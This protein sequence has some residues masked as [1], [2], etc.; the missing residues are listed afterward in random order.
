MVKKVSNVMPDFEY[1][2]KGDN[3]TL[4][5]H[6]GT[7]GDEYGVIDIVR[8]CVE[9]YEGR[10][11]D[12]VFVPVVSPSAVKAKIR[13]NSNGFDLNR[14][15][16]SDSKEIEVI[17]NIKALDG[18]KFNLM[19]SFHEDPV[20]EEYYVYESSF[21]SGESEKIKNLNQKLKGLGI[22]LL[23]GVDDPDDPSLGFEFVEGYRKF[24]VDKNNKSDGYITHWALI[25]AGVKTAFS[26]ETPS[27]LSL[28]KKELIVDTFFKDLLIKGS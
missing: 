17:E 22:K 4:L 15:F 18:Y 20:Y 11:P 5:I 6:S 27:K 26:V 19:V 7:H 10:L 24:V 16:F 14:I 2:V 21:E 8:K 28:E 13:V 3:P 12:F 25:N 1:F 23:N 9:K